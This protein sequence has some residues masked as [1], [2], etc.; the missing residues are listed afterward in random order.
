M[1]S[2]SYSHGIWRSHLMLKVTEKTPTKLV[3]KDQHKTIAVMTAFFTVVSFFAVVLNIGQGL[4]TF[5]LRFRNGEQIHALQITA[6]VIFVCFGVAFTLVLAIVTLHFGR[7]VTFILDKTEEVMKLQRMGLF[8][9]NYIT[10]S[11]YGISHL[12]IEENSDVRAY[13]LWLVL[14]S[15]ERIALGTLSALDEDEIDTLRKHVHG[16]LRA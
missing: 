13:G 11:I 10:H 15:G 4:D 16:F 14:R 6:F 7:G 8:R 12:H 1:D 5:I 2:V 9:M 3:L